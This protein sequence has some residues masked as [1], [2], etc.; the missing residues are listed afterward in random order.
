MPHFVIE[1][2]DDLPETHNLAA[3]CQLVFDTAVASDNFDPPTIKVRARPCPYW[4]TGT[5]P[6]SFVHVTIRMMAGR[7]TPTKSR[8][9]ASILVALDN[10][11][12]NVGSLSVDIKEIDPKTY[13]KRVI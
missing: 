4:R 12:P 10:Q 7:D 9:T 13:A 2:S 6:Q 3:L 11:M 8:L 5:E 1:Y